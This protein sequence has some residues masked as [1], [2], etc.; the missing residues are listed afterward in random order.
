[1]GYLNIVLYKKIFKKSSQKSLTGLHNKH[2][3]V[4]DGLLNILKIQNGLL[5]LN[6]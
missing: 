5:F 3:G 4:S 1:M 2:V 6:G